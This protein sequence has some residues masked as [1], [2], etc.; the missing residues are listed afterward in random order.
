MPL[1]AKSIFVFLFCA[2][3]YGALA[4]YSNAYDQGRKDALG[5][6]SQVDYTRGV[7]D[8]RETARRE[9]NQESLSSVEAQVKA[10]VQEYEAQINQQM[11]ARLNQ[12]YQSGQ[13]DYAKR[14]IDHDMQFVSS[15]PTQK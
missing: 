7:K 6:K 12:A 2:G 13:S 8:G 11:N 1:L 15:K 5:D 10:K 3:W 4:G 14:V 9:L